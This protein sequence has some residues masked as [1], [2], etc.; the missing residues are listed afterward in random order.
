MGILKSIGNFFLFLLMGL[1]ISLVFTSMMVQN[2]MYST[3]NIDKLLVDNAK[4]YIADHKTE[5]KSFLVN[6]SR[7]LNININKDQMKTMCAASDSPLSKDFCLKLDAFSEVQA[8]NAFVQD[9]VDKQIDG[10]AFDKQISD[11]ALQGKEQITNSI[12]SVKK[13]IG[14]PVNYLIA[15]IIGYL[16]VAGMV[17]LISGFSVKIALYKIGRNTLFN[18][19]PFVAFSIYILLLTPQK[20]LGM[21]AAMAGSTEISKLPA[22]IVNMILTIILNIAK[23]AINPVFVVAV[24]VVLVSL[25]LMIAMKIMKDD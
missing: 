10:G 7:T 19:L 17:F 14:N 18:T 22:I 23:S 8:Q 11:F 16:L 20:V 1:C 13:V 3:D 5:V 25:A 12:D 24:V 6:Q 4:Q 9:I 15:G 2:L 21:I